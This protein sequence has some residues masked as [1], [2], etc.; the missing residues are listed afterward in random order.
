MG[1]FDSGSSIATVVLYLKLNGSY[2]DRLGSY[3]A[4]LPRLKHLYYPLGF[5]EPSGAPL[6]ELTK[7][8]ANICPQLESNA[9]LR[10]GEPPVVAWVVRDSQGIVQDAVIRDRWAMEVAVHGDDAFP[11]TQPYIKHFHF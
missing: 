3:M 5:G 7:K 2:Q 6:L 8:L 9:H 11:E 4:R 1:E 10:E